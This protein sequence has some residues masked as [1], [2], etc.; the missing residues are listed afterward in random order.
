M[1]IS[2]MQRLR[3]QSRGDT[4][5]EV[6]VAI[7]V[8]ALVLGGAY[9]TTNRSLMATRAA[10]ERATALKLAESQVEQLK[11]LA[12]SDPAVLFGPGAP[13][14]FCVSSATGLPA[15]ANSTACAVDGNGSP[16]SSEPVYRL[17][18]ARAGSN[19]TL[20]ATWFNVNGSSTENLQLRYRV[21]E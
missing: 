5:V 14:P 13:S 4:I 16:T 21:Y 15:A 3:R 17:S 6:M 20:T 12:E 7:A 10:Q 9:V 1:H 19:F 18:I 2:L 8:V 11:G